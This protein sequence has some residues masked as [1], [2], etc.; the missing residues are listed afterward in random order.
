MLNY[1]PKSVQK[2]LATLFNYVLKASYALDRRDREFTSASLHAF[3]IGYYDG[4]LFHRVIKDYIVQTGDPSGTGDGVHAH[5]C[6]T[7]CVL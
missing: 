1:G 3:Y 7:R 2:P 4:C 5:R 6:R